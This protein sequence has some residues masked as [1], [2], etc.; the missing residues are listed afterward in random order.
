MPELSRSE[1]LAQVTEEII[2]PDQR[3]I[4]PHHHLWPGVSTKSGEESSQY[5]LEDLW[6]DTGSGHNVTNTVFIDCGQCYWNESD[7]R[8]NP[9]GETEF[10]K[11]IADEANQDSSQANISGIVGHVNMLLGAKADDVLEKHVEVGGLL[12]KGI[13][14]AGGWDPHENVRSSHHNATEGLYLS[15]PFQE[16]LNTLVKRDMVFEAWQY[17]HQI[18][19]ITEM[20]KKH[21]NLKIILNHFSGPLGIGPYVNKREEIFTKWKEDLKELSM[22]DNVYAKLGGLAMPVNGFGFHLAEKPP[23]SDEFIE[24]Q[25]DYYLTALDFFEPERC[26]FESNFPVDKASISYSVL[27]NAFKKIAEDFSET[28]KD[29]LFF[30][31][32]MQAYKIT[33]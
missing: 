25:K 31:T 33:D 4:D 21:P 20:A 2:D 27:W 29:A 8:M 24:L 5:L 28:E 13:R 16:G 19:Q 10:V 7:S 18:P 23:S 30:R 3:I 32:A 17:H 14:H 11:N 12:F 6:A 15:D 26:M 9:V 1:W 22:H